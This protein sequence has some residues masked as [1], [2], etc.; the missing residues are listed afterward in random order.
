M[1]PA[2]IIIF[3]NQKGGVGKTTLYRERDIFAS[4]CG[5]PV[6]LVETVPQKPAS[7]DAEGG[8]R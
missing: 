4:Q 3:S 7:A 6:I 1:K 5:V 8:A 2:I